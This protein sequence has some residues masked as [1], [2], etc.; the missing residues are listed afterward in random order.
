VGSPRFSILIT[1]QVV[2]HVNNHDEM[3]VLL[4]GHRSPMNAIED[5]EFSKRWEKIRTEI[6]TLKV[7]LGVSAH[8]YI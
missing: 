8:W 6:P 4:I 1:F 7:I 3:P 2:M 5:N